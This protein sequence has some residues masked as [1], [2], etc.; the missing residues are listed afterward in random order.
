MVSRAKYK[1]EV[2][3]GVNVELYRSTTIREREYTLNFLILAITS[4]KII[5]SKHT[6]IMKSQKHKL[7]KTYML[8]RIFA[9]LG[10]DC[11]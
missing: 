10:A 7:R 3:V 4:I 1:K 2:E 11:L 8:Y 5:V 9:L 6:H